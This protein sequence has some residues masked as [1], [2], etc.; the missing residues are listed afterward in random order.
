MASNPPVITMERAREEFEVV[1]FNTVQ[2]LFDKTGAGH[3]AV[4]DRCW[5]NGHYMCHAAEC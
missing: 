2:D 1:M 5:G 3:R 4:G